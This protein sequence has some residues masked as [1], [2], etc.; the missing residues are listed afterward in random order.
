MP[1]QEFQTPA[2]NLYSFQRSEEEVTPGYDRESPFAHPNPS[3]IQNLPSSINPSYCMFPDPSPLTLLNIWAFLALLTPS[4]FVPFP[5][6]NASQVILLHPNS[7]CQFKSL[8][9][10]QLSQKPLLT[11][12]NSLLFIF[13]SPNTSILLQASQQL[14]QVCLS[15]GEM[16]M[17][18]YW[19]W[20]KNHS[21]CYLH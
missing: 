9:A 16:K 5:F 1:W 19:D 2:P 3:S 21:R 13:L 18:A 10:C 14:V 6:P 11:P 8:R 20:R 15:E 7:F 4:L 12:P 17:Q